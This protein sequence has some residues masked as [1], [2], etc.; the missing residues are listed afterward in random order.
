MIGDFDPDALAAD[1]YAR[2]SGENSHPNAAGK[3]LNVSNSSPKSSSIAMTTS[4][5]GYAP[6]VEQSGVSS[7]SSS[8]APSRFILP[9][10][11]TQKSPVK[12]TSYQERQKVTNLTSFYSPAAAALEMFDA[13]E[14]KSPARVLAPPS[15]PQSEF[16]EVIN[17]SKCI[18]IGNNEG[19]EKTSSKK[20]IAECGKEAEKA[21]KSVNDALIREPRITSESRTS[22]I[23]S[24]NVREAEVEVNGLTVLQKTLV[25]RGKVRILF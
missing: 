8:F 20:K 4:Q 17:S 18:E 25:R 7:A 14:P 11:A 24:K 5:K 22:E 12:S 16:I 1:F 21:S 9:P 23:D 15:I 3:S 6:V 19:L 13:S 10:K 2:K